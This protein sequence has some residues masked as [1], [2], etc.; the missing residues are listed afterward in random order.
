MATEQIFS[1]ILSSTLVASLVSA[2]F[3]LLTRRK[4]EYLENITKERKEWREK[5]REISKS[6]AIAKD[7]EALMFAI[8]KLKVRINVYGIS[9]SYLHEDTFIWEYVRKVER[10]QNDKINIEK[11]KTTLIELISC[12]LKYD[13]ERSKDEVKGNVQ[14]KIFVGATI[15]SFFLYSIFFFL[16]F[17]ID[18]TNLLSFYS[19]CVIFIFSAF[20]NIVI[21]SH[22][23]SWNSRKQLA[24]TIIMVALIFV[25]FFT[26][27]FVFIRDISSLS[28][29]E[30]III[31]APYI[32][33]VYTFL[34]R[35]LSYRNNI[36]R[37]VMSVCVILDVWIP[38]KYNLA[39]KKKI[40]KCGSIEE[41]K[42]LKARYRFLS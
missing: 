32:G 3:S 40:R 22:A 17:E 30:F 28:V 41:F 23:D 31:L 1:M 29:F 21:I 42:T 7:I 11:T 5:I 14:L 38:E 33:L 2:I 20:I 35:A 37:L 26:L 36:G 19:Y 27:Y 18:K 15:M 16:K 9:S 8:D 25:S 4:K 6:I 13:W 12:V 39:V 24:F 10:T 34:I